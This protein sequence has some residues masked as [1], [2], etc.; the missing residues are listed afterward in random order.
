MCKEGPTLPAIG[1]GRGPAV[2]ADR[3]L[4]LEAVGRHIGNL[5]AR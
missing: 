2:I 5:P 1:A 4:R 3:G